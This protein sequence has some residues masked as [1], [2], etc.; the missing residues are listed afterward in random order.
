MHGRRPRP[1]HQMQAFRD[2]LDDYG[3]MD[4]GYKGYPFTWCNNRDPTCTTWVCL[5]HGVASVD[6]LQKFPTAILEHVDVT[7]SN[8]KCLSLVG[9]PYHVQI[10]DPSVLKKIG[11]AMRAALP[12]LK[13][14]G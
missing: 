13:K 2:A 7:N 10:G 1:D 3:L 4:L 12:L 5:D 8:H 14:L 9:A 6:W 11:P